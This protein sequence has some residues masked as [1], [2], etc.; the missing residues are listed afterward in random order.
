MP[1][2]PVD[3]LTDFALRQRLIDDG[4]QSKLDWVFFVLAAASSVW[5]TVIVVDLGMRPSPWQIPLWLLFWLV[6]AYLVLPRLHR[7][8]TTLYV[9]NY[10]IGRARTS[11]GLLGDPVNVG[12]LGSADEIHTV[13]QAAGWTLADPVSWRSS[14]RIVTATVL[15]KSYDEAPVSPLF[16][17]GRK[18]DFAYQQEVNG[19]PGK[20]HHVRFWKAPEG[21]L[22]PGGTA[23]DWLAAGTYDRKVGF[24]AFTLQITHKIA[25]DTDS[26]R[27][28]IVECA[29]SEGASVTVLQDFSTGYHSRNGGGDSIQTDGNLPIVDVRAC[30]VNPDAAQRARNT[31]TVVAKPLAIVLGAALVWLGALSTVNDVVDVWLHTHDI[32]VEFDGTELATG[33][34]IGLSV[35]FIVL[36]LVKVLL[37]WLVLIGSGWA[38]TL[39]LTLAALTLV[40]QLV[41]A[42]GGATELTH[43]D[44]SI[45]LAADIL[46]LLALSSESAAAYV[47]RRRTA[48]AASRPAGRERGA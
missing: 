12:W 38:R 24:S 46:T 16:L 48:L 21:W 2:S 19:S 39:V 30:A 18:E 1:S 37:G 47:R 4:L 22:L 15:R 36:A 43:L 33:V 5:L 34:V 11:D 29:R 7:I 14:W 20:R 25:P 9:P 23:V 28:H 31:L 10:F 42:S 44:T 40:L 13:M 17:F 45:S 6:L 32:Q 3:R 8:L 26:E 35:F 27:D 41:L